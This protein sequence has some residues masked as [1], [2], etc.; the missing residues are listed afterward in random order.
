MNGGIGWDNPLAR[1]RGYSGIS[2]VAQGGIVSSAVMQANQS[3]LRMRTVLSLSIL[4]SNEL[5]LGEYRERMK[6]HLPKLRRFNKKT[7]K[8]EE[9][10]NT[11][12]SMESSQVCCLSDIPVAHL[13]YHAK[14]Y[15][16]FAVG[17]HREAAVRHGFNPVFYTLYN[18]N[19]PRSIRKVHVKMRK[20]AANSIYTIADDIKD[21]IQDLEDLDYEQTRDVERDLNRSLSD[22]RDGINAMEDAVSSAQRG[23]KEFLAFVKT[24]DKKEFTSIYCEREW[25]STEQF[26]FELD[27]LAMIV[28]PKSGRGMSYFNDFVTGKYALK[29]PRSIPVVPWEDLIEH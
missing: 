27:D 11:T 8:M 23:F 17:F 24:F 3:R 2:L 9:L 6:V 21:Y 14:R 16:K 28:L 4:K 13:S 15:G 5:R 10:K 29:L 7:R 25:R 18:S 19:V 22:L 20:V 26:S 12:V 1:C